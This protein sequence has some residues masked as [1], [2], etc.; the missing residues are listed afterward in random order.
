[1][2]SRATLICGPSTVPLRATMFSILLMTPHLSDMVGGNRDRFWRRWEGFKT[3]KSLSTVYSLGDHL[4][5][6][7][8]PEDVRELRNVL[9]L[10]RTLQ[11]QD[12]LD[13]LY[14]LYT[15]LQG[16]CPGFPKPNYSIPPSTLWASAASAIIQ[17]MRCLNSIL[18]V[19]HDK[20]DNLPS[21]SFNWGLQSR[22]HGH[23]P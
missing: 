17:S 20:Q 6:W 22:K 3:H 15:I 1:M 14:S 21:W 8:R 10:V 9:V 5:T 23:S 13:R 11:A 12:P 7:K 2:A 19:H 16:F 18:D 4:D